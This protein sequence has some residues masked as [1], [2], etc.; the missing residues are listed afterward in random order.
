MA[1]IGG[2]EA[3][4]KLITVQ[5][6]LPGDI[7]G[8]TDAIR[9]IMLLGEVQA[10]TIKNGEPITYQRFVRDGEEALPRESTQSFA[11]LTPLQVVRNISMEEWSAAPE[12]RNARPIEKLFWMFLHM[13]SRRWVVTHVIVGE[14]TEFWKWLGLPS[15]MH[16]AVDQFLGARI[17]R[18]KLLPSETFILCGGRT[19]SATI[20]EVGHALKGSTFEVIDEAADEKSS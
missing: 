17:E 6:T 3:A 9:Q 11:E 12:V 1:G 7:D 14:S 15:D 4:G 8:I 13:A 10:I 19:R 16:E 18:D 2:Q 5:A 20:A